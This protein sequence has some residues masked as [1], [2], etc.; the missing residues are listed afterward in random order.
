M[1]ELRLCATCA[2]RYSFSMKACPHC[3]AEATKNAP[4]S[5]QLCEDPREGCTGF[6]TVKTDKW[7]CGNCFTVH[8]LALP[9]EQR[10]PGYEAFK[11]K[12]QE[13]QR[14]DSAQ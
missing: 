5:K 10:G 8:Q 9:T 4:I 14:K 7:R 6:G 13:A 2:T 1:A 11:A 3:K 12:L